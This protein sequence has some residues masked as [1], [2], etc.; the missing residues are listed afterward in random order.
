MH[1]RVLGLGLLIFVSH[2][3]AQGNSVVLGV[4][5][6]KSGAVVPGA[7]VT[8]VNTGTGLR[9]NAQSDESGRYYLSRLD[10]GAYRIEVA[11]PGFRTALRTGINLTGQQTLQLNLSLQVGEVTESITVSGGVAAIETST[12][13]VRSVIRRE[14]IQDLPLNGRNALQLQTL[15]PGAVNHGGARTTFSQE[16]GI[17]VNGAR[18]S[19]NNV[20]LDG[21][22]H[23]DAYA[24][25]P[26][27][28]PNPD[29]LQEFTVLSSTFS[30]EYG[31]GAGALVSAVTRSGTNRYRGTLYDFLRNNALDARSY[32]GHRGLVDKPTLRRNQFG[33][34]LGGPVKRD[35]TFFF[36]SWESLRERS[37]I[38]NTGLIVPTALERTGNYS[39]SARKPNDPLTGRRFPDDVIPASRI[40]RAAVLREE[41]LVPLPNFAGNQYVYNSPG[42]DDRNQ[43][44]GR[45]DHAFNDNHRFNFS[46]F[47]SVADQ[48][49]NFNI[50]LSNGTVNWIN[51]RLTAAYTSVLSPAVVHAFTY[52]MNFADVSRFPVPIL[53]ERFPGKPPG[54]APGF[55]YSDIGVR[56]QS[57]DPKSVMGTRLGN[58]SGYYNINGINLVDDHPRVHE[59]RDTV[60]VVRGAHLLKL[61]GE[62]TTSEVARVNNFEMDGAS[63]AWNASKTGNGHGDYLLGLPSNYQQYSLLRSLNQSRIAGLFAQDDWKVTPVFT[64][65]LGFRWEPG[66]G[67]WDGRNEIIAFRPGQQSTQYPNALPGMLYPGDAGISRTTHRID[68]NNFAPRVGLAWLPFGPNS[69]TSIRSAYGIFYNTGGRGFLLNETQLNQPFVLR[70]QIPDPPSFEDPWRNYAGGDPF[71]FQ[72]PQTA[73]EKR[74]FQFARPTA[75]GR[76]FGADNATPYSQQWNFNLQHEILPGTVLTAGYV[77]SKGTRLI[78]NYEVNTAAFLPGNGPDGRPLSTTGNID[79][80]RRYLGFQ[81]I[82]AADTLG[83]SS[84][85]SFQLTANRRLARGVFF[86]ANYTLSKSLDLQSLD[87]N[88]GTPQDSNNFRLERGLSDFDRRHVFVTSFLAEIPSPWKKGVGRLLTSGWQANGIYSYSAGSPL[89]VIPGND[90]A[91]RGDGTQRVNVTG[92]FR[93]PGGRSFDEQRRN[94]FNT[95]AFAAAPIGSFGNFARNG[96]IG[97]G[98]YNMDLALFKT[99]SVRER[100]TVQYRWELFNAFNHANLDAPVTNLLSA[101]FGQ[102]NT[103][104][105]PRIMQMG[106]KLLF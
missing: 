87:R 97:P 21:G 78:I 67:I 57:S 72:P 62:F 91:L 98:R 73:D 54:I 17:S 69:K 1:A 44:I 105:G 45:L 14:L 83:N 99:T 51:N 74:R 23:T 60:T 93:L 2:A 42:T 19:D 76:Y 100:F 37:A 8:L 24:G 40:S 102:I 25:T 85:H 20:L 39:A 53:P 29:A 81:S 10:V 31:R 32:F 68:W 96:L 80:R 88:A 66:F 15:L 30:A 64:L 103:V 89:N 92:N 18:G 16:D 58:I 94:Y 26:N 56:T 50:P 82:N 41:I 36:V 79:A 106:L 65:N 12:S 46:Y 77:G 47:Y 59:F 3:V 35:K 38:T 9:H 27:T 101:A 49:V 104:T 90:R 28:M 71:P 95:G 34:A 33:A 63:F 13:T 48:A 86:M 6:D 7:R 55:R 43:F 52:T 22:T 61:G 11:A 70:I 5:D 75:I 4:I 84:Y